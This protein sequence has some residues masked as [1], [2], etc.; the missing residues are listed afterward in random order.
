MRTSTARFP[1]SWGY[2]VA[3]YREAA[4]GAADQLEATAKT[5]PAAETARAQAEHAREWEGRRQE[6]RLTPTLTPPLT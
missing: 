6:V 2:V 5:A 3:Q 1:V 4:P